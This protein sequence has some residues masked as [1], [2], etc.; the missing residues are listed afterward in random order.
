M[1]DRSEPDDRQALEIQSREDD[2]PPHGAVPP[3]T[4]KQLQVPAGG[5]TLPPAAEVL[6]TKSVDKQ[7]TYIL[8]M[9]ESAP[10]NWETGKFNYP[11]MYRIGTIPDG[12]CF[13]HALASAYFLPYRIGKLGEVSLNRHQFIS[14]LRFD[15]SRKLADKVDLSREDSPIH[16]DL[17]SRG[18]LRKFAENVPQYS[19]ESMMRELNSNRSVDNVYNEFISNILN[20]DIY[21]LSLN[22]QDVYVTGD[23]SDILFKGRNSIVILEMPGHYEL[24]GIQASSGIK[25]LFHPDHPFIKAIRIRLREKIDLGSQ[26]SGSSQSLS[27]NQ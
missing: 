3:M 15:L 24:V 6:H 8:Q 20:K 22:E 23:D 14:D 1:A 18:Q 19:Q 26:I 7:R 5:V 12:S 2:S 17:L 27:P 21:L 11:N 13:F 9:M 16:Y 4:M 10:L 25:T